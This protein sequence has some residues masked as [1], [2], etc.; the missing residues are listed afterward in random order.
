MH[1]N[2]YL[3]IFKHTTFTCQQFKVSLVQKAVE[4]RILRFSYLTNTNIL[5]L[6]ICL[7]YSRE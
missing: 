2:T 1:T 7:V 4:E 6:Y 3:N 5:L